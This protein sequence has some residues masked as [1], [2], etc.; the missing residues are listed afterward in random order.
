[1][2]VMGAPAAYFGPPRTQAH[3]QAVMS[4][5][6]ERETAKQEA[7]HK[8]RMRAARAAWMQLLQVNWPC[9]FVCKACL[10]SVKD[11]PERHEFER[12]AQAWPGQQTTQL[13]R[14]AHCPSLLEQCYC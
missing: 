12:K 10:S 6:L 5:Y 13:W 3:E 2:Y 14:A 8:Q 7:A 11:M 4:E 1:M 9:I